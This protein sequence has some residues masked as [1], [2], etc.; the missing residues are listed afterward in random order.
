MASL[1]AIF[2]R[3]TFGVILDPFKD[4]PPLV[5]YAYGVNSG[6]GAF[7]RFEP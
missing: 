5:V 6:E 4:D 1:T 2:N 7:E 3:D